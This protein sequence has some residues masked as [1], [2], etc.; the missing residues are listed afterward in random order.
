LKKRSGASSPSEPPEPL[1]LFID[2]SLGNKVV[3]GALRAA[4]AHGEIHDDHFSPTAL[5][6]DWLREVGRRGWVIV[7]KDRDIRYRAPALAAIRAS[8][9]RLFVLTAGDLQGSEM[10]Q[11]FVKALRRMAALSLREPAPF[12]AKIVRTGVV[13]LLLSSRQFR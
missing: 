11:M 1:V 12:I 5:D 9:V 4:G 8:A 2:R 6:E 3:A 10:G 7:T 13:S